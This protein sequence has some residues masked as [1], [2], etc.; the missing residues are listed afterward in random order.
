MHKSN[1]RRMHCDRCL[2]DWARQAGRARSAAAIA[3]RTSC[4]VMAGT[5]PSTDPSAGFTTSMVFPSEESTQAPSTWHCWRKR[6]GLFSFIMV[7]A[8]MEES[9]GFKQ[10]AGLA[11]PVQ[12][13][14]SVYQQPPHRVARL[15]GGAADVRRQ[16]DV[17]EFAIAGVDAGLIG[18][19]VQPRGEEPVRSQ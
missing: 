10:V 8:G 19:D 14:E 11:A 13:V 18:K 15:P 9:V 17:V 7:S 12:C 1:Q 6:E 5:L 3:S 4:C 2:A 16:E